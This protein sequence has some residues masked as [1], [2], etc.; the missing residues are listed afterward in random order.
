MNSGLC[1]GCMNPLKDQVVSMKHESIK[2]LFRL[3]TSLR[4]T[5]I[6]SKITLKKKLIPKN[7]LLD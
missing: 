5:K 3:C 2:N 1:R 4:V 7:L 6:L